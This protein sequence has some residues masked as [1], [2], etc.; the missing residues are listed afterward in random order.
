MGTTPGSSPLILLNHWE[1][2]MTVATELITI[3]LHTAELT[4]R[5]ARLRVQA[6]D[7]GPIEATAFRRRAAELELEAWAVAVRAGA[8]VALAA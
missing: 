5:A 4:E 3:D 1:Y 8:D 7:L 2:D 6:E